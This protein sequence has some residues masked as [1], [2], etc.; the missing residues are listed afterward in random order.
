M[1]KTA[2]QPSAQK[3]RDSIISA[4]EKLFAEKGF[5]AMT[6]RDVTKEAGVNLAA[7]NYHFG[8]KIKLMHAVIERRIEPIN[9]ERI[10]RLDAHIEKCAP[11]AVPLEDIFEALFRPFFDHAMLAKGPDPAFIQMIGRAMTEPADFMRKMHKEFFVEL[12]YRFMAELK[13]TCPELSDQDLQLRFFLSVSTML[14]TITEQTRLENISGG[15]LSGK[16]LDRVC[17]ELTSYVVSGFKQNE[18][19]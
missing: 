18:Q 14:G 6:L 8:S 12:S 10:E 5:R 3:T 19:K 1:S 7:V 9:R 15:K 13:R 11:A 17:D 2:K 4:A 16:D